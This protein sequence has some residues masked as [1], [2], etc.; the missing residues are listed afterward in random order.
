[1]LFY[2]KPVIAIAS[3]PKMLALMIA[4]TKIPSPAKTIWADVRGPIQEPA[5]HNIAE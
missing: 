4:P 5:M 1:M 3:S 2:Y